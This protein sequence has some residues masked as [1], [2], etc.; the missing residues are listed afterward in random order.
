VADGVVPFPCSVMPEILGPV[1]D[2]P[3]ACR[4]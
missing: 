3:R 2:R 1:P 4:S